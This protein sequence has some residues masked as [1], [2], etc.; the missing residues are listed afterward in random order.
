MARFLAWAIFHSITECYRELWTLGLNTRLVPSAF[1]QVAAASSWVAYE[2]HVRVAAGVSGSCLEV[3]CL[4]LT[5]F[6][7]VG[8]PRPTD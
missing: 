3:S 4:N 2:S 1:H 5:P 8:H 6:W 7:L